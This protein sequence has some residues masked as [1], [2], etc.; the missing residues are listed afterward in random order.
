MIR[1]TCPHTCFGAIEKQFPT[2]EEALEYV[3]ICVQN[4][5]YCE[6]ETFN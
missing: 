1:V 2:I 5:V 6:I 4:K 3:G